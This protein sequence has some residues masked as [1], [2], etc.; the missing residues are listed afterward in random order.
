[1]RRPLR[2][3][4]HAAAAAALLLAA[5]APASDAVYEM[6]EVPTGEQM[7]LDLILVRPLS[8]AGTVLGIG[9]FVVALPINALTLN[10]KEPARRLVLEP[11]QY[12][13]V[14]RLGD[15]D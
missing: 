12:T 13:F 8:L 10:F 15:L 4:A 14:R 9:V 6:D 7:A 2:F 3:V 5:A 11:A 1:M